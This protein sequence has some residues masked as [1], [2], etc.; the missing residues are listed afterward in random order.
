MP[1]TIPALSQKIADL[2]YPVD[3]KSSQRLNDALVRQ[4][5]PITEPY[6]EYK[7][8]YEELLKRVTEAKKS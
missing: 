4:L 3:G 2:V 1:V 6:E 7:Q 5:K 8:K